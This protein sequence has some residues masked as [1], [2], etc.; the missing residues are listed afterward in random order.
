M[1]MYD[2]VNELVGPFPSLGKDCANEGP[3]R[4]SLKWCPLEQP[5]PAWVTW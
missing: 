2:Y 1:K 5:L 4:L 3:V